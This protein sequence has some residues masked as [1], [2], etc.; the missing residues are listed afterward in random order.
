M[1]A[2]VTWCK[3]IKKNLPQ[4]FFNLTKDFLLNKKNTLGIAR[5]YL[6]RILKRK[7][8]FPS[9]LKINL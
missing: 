7:S 9:K 3:H 1:G 8:I 2:K 6:P 4:R 5:E